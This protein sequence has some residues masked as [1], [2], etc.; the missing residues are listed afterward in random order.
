M[1][2]YRLQVL[3]FIY[4]L[5]L[6]TFSTYANR[7]ITLL[8][9]RITFQIPTNDIVKNIATYK[10]PRRGVILVRTNILTGKDFSTATSGSFSIILEKQLYSDNYEIIP[11]H[12]KRLILDNCKNKEQFIFAK[13]SSEYLRESHR[14]LHYNDAIIG[15]SI[16]WIDSPVEKYPWSTQIAY[17][18]FFIVENT[19]L[20]VEVSFLDKYKDNTFPIMFPQYF[21]KE[22]GEFYWK[23]EDTLIDFYK[24]L[25]SNEYVKLPEGIRLLKETKDLILKTF[26]IN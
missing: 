14:L 16:L 22:K 20:E 26:E 10:G 17:T 18:M 21:Y 9:G 6:S 11:A 15:E 3:L 12:I 1:R 23:S 19:I 24:F 13:N 2:N 5:S 7:P 25:E 8:D 4:L